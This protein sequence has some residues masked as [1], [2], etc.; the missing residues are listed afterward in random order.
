MIRILEPNDLKDINTQIYV[1][2][3]EEAEKI[4]TV[5]DVEKHFMWSCTA[6]FALMFNKVWIKKADDK[7]CG[8][9]IK[10]VQIGVTEQ[11]AY[12]AN[13]SIGKQLNKRLFAHSASSSTSA[14]KGQDE[15]EKKSSGKTDKKTDNKS[16]SKT[17]S[18]HA[19]NDDDDDADDAD[20]AD[21]A[22]NADDADDAD[23]ADNADNADDVDENDASDPEDEPEEKPKKGSKTNVVADKNVK[24]Q[25]TAPK[26]ASTEKKPASKKPAKK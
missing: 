9:G 7:G 16:S 24:V 22:D 11:P 3:K 2:D 15:S 1:G 10:C 21:N 6:Q 18:R 17:N 19:K 25:K 14:S 8:I 4:K 5:T 26:E 23:D 12:K 20:D 13:Q